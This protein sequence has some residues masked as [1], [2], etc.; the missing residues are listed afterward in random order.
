MN[1]KYCY[2]KGSFKGALKMCNSNPNEIYHCEYCEL[3]QTA[4]TTR[5]D[6]CQCVD[7]KPDFFDG[8]YSRNPDDFRVSPTPH[9]YYVDDNNCLMPIPDELPPVE[10]VAPDLS[11]KKLVTFNLT[12]D[13]INSIIIGLQWSINHHKSLPDS[14]FCDEYERKEIFQKIQSLKLSFMKHKDNY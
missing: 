1:S 9:G 6:V 14:A 13:E 3:E 11:S 5:H 8:L 7:D 2:N 12:Q 10:P 4:D